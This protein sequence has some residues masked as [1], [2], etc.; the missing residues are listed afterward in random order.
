[1]PP[2]YF[3]K[4]HKGIVS[5]HS[6]L[7]IHNALNL[8]TQT[9]NITNPKHQS[10]RTQQSSCARYSARA[11]ADLSVG[12]A[13]SATPPEC[14]KCKEDRRFRGLDM[15]GF[16]VYDAW[17]MTRERWACLGPGNCLYDIFRVRQPG[18]REGTLAGRR[19]RLHASW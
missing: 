3:Y 17:F 4:Y 2:K 8:E 7:F 9:L 13:L 19:Q 18:H 6:D 10:A 14:K 12:E 1:M 15:F 16:R 11:A 5:S